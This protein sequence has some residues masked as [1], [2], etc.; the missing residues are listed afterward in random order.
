MLVRTVDMI[1]EEGTADAALFPVRPIHEVI[2]DK[3]AAAVEE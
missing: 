2:D 3:L 1:C